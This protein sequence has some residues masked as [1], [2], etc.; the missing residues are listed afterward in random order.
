MP[1]RHALIASLV[2]LAFCS[3]LAAQDSSANTQGGVLGL[4][5]DNALFFV[6]RRGHAAVREAFLKSNLG[7]MT[8]DETIQ[9]FVHGSRVE[10]GKWIMKAMFDLQT[11]AEA[12]AWQKTLH[13]FLT[14]FWYQPC[15]A[16]LVVKVKGPGGGPQ[17]GFICATG[18][19]RAECKAALDKLT[20]FGVPA[21]GKPGRRQAFTYKKAR[22]VWNGVA[23]SHEE[24]ELPETG[25]D[26]AE[27]LNSK[28]L[29]MST[30]LG[31]TM[32]LA[33]GLEA[34][35]SLSGMLSLTQRQKSIR[36]NASLAVVLKKTEVKDWAFRWFLDA[37]AAR[38]MIR[39]DRENKE[40]AQVM[41]AI[42]IDKV[43]GVGGSGGYADN[44][45]V[46]RTYIHAPGHDRGFIRFMTRGGSYKKA[47]A[48]APD[49]SSFC[50]AG[51]N[52]PKTIARMIRDLA[53]PEPP[54]A[55]APAEFEGPAAEKK[56][57]SKRNAEILKHVDALAASADG[58]LAVFVTELQALMGMAMNA[59]GPPIG[60][61]IGAKDSAKAA[62]ALAALLKTVG[63]TRENEEGQPG[64]KPAEKPAD[65]AA[66]EAPKRPSAYRKIAI[67]RLHPML[68]M[69]V[70]KDR[71]ILA[72]N[73]SAL[74]ATIDTAIDGTG[75]FPPGSKGEKLVKL[76]G[77]GPTI[78]VMDL[79]AV[80][81]VFWPMLVQLAGKAET[82]GDEFPLASLPSA[83][84][85]AR[86]LGPE[87]AVLSPDDD[88]LMM[89]STGLVPFAT[90]FAMFSPLYGGLFF[91]MMAM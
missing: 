42:G 27:A 30:W 68:S 36:E 60:F 19:Y 24:F 23:K 22:A 57:P 34:A 58:R 10:I 2:L 64:D 80:V 88:G 55:P 52:D 3:P 31:G 84:K 28:S 66:G 47:H 69:A 20:A 12:A 5:P 59:G 17:F 8:R 78:F 44:V 16:F 11:P 89:R 35:D 65:A 56:K 75:G 1:N 61:V 90:K 82:E 32:F 43:Q 39:G 81:R 51:Q 9:S 83:N 48:M 41:K 13:E 62:D 6:E 63:V 21:K 76:A 86:M 29:F 79:A 38:K 73:D 71:V 67:R 53:P 40:F 25:E 45:F 85:L 46:R 50:L 18:K 4:I 72:M 74:K 77:E 7:E 87:V 37:T 49:T 33:T 15:A 14:P 26:R 54:K 70:M 91:L